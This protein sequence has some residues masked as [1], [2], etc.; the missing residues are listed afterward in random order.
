MTCLHHLNDDNKQELY[1][2]LSDLAAEMIT[3]GHKE[4]QLCF[5]CCMHTAFVAI[6]TCVAHNFKLNLDKEETQ[7]LFLDIYGTSMAAAIGSMQVAKA[8]H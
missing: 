1:D 4:K 3:A 2:K 6:M 8:R 7:A 5:S